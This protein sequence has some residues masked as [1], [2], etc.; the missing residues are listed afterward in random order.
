MRQFLFVLIALVT[1]SCSKDSEV[2]YQPKTL[3]EY[4]ESTYFI[5]ERYA[6]VEDVYYATRRILLKVDFEDNCF[7]KQIAE[8]ETEVYSCFI[9][10][11]S[12]CEWSKDDEYISDFT[13]TEYEITGYARDYEDRLTPVRFQRSEKGITVRLNIK[14]LPVIDFWQETTLAN[15]DKDKGQVSC[16]Q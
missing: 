7:V 1:L 13:G 2:E 8:Y 16:S 14:G 3:R 4:M 12:L 15:W 5:A 10:G 11:Q 9:D 6:V